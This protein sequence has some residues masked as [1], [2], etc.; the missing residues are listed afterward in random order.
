MVDT[1]VPPTVDSVATTDAATVAV[2]PT[3]AAP[4]TAAPT[5]AAPRPPVPDAACATESTLRSKSGAVTASLHIVNNTTETVQA[6][7][8]DYTGKRVVYGTVA[9]FSSV[10]QP[11]WVTHPWIIANQQGTCYRLIVMTSPD[12]T[13]SVDPGP[14]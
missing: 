6:I 12:Q 5:T 14:G 3:T 8:L 7:W 9:P 2:A 1:T 13:V 10:V 4:T 11:T